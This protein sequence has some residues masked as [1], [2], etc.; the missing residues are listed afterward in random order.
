MIETKRVKVLEARYI[1]NVD[2]VSVDAIAILGECAEG[3]FRT[4]INSS[5]FSFGNK[6]K[7]SEMKKTAELLI[8]K[9]INLE[10]ETDNINNVEI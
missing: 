4:Q 7:A 1:D 10:F 6:D 3:K 2:S 9:T 8:G 5:C